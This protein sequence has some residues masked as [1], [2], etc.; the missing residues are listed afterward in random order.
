MTLVVLMS[1]SA[2]SATPS[3]ARPRPD[4]EAVTSSAAAARTGAAQVDDA[5]VRGL[6]RTEFSGLFTVDRET[7]SPNWL[8]GDWDGNGRVDLVVIG[9]LRMD[10]TARR[11]PGGKYPMYS[12]LDTGMDPAAYDEDVTAD[13]MTDR[14]GSLAQLVVFDALGAGMHGRTA[15]FA[16]MDGGTTRMGLHRG[17]LH[18]APAGTSAPPPP[19]LL[20]DVV[21]LLERDGTGRA[22][23][24]DG[25]RFRLYPWTPRS[26]DR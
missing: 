13:E 16:A 9:R 20:G 19:K 24:W 12:P 4:A 18:P 22:L 26:K 11:H 6:V 14:A 7:T 23:Y 3:E 8:L 1:G 15:L 5:W 25:E 2:A 10:A 21:L 17:A